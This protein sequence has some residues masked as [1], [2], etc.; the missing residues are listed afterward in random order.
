MKAIIAAGG[1]GTR[2]YPLTFT[3]NK[4]LIPIA[5]RPLLSYPI[6]NVV[7]VGIKDVGVIVNPD[8]RKAV[9]D[10]VGDGSRWGIKVTYVEQ[11]AP[12]GLAHVVKVSEKFL[13]GSSF[14]YHLGDNIFSKGIKKPFEVFAKKKPD[15]LLTVVEHDENF[16]LGVPFFD[17]KGNLK[18]VVEKPK[19]PPN[20]YG[21][22]GLYMFSSKV[23]EAFKGK[24]QV[25]PSARGELE[26]VD[27]YNY[28]L[29]HGKKVEVAEVDGEWRDPGKFD[30]SL[31]ANKLMLEEKTKTKI[32]GKVDKDTSLSGEIEIGKGSRVVNSRIVGPVSIGENVHVRN[33]FIGPFTSIANECEIVNSSIEYSILMDDIHL[34]DVKGK[35][36]ASMIGKHTEIRTPKT[37]TRAPVYSFS[38][39][40][41]CTI[42]LPF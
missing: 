25:K 16:R 13:D 15:A 6:E 29:T 2:L 34:V 11:S 35:I 14:V 18:E 36:E 20:Q 37:K 22:P 19:S 28:M 1:K 27:L 33:S 12:L 23:F 42:E 9:E 38:V 8:T 30:D 7:E 31:E 5:N 10:Y 41:H 40:D 39:A 24:D 32:D 26:I 4:H 17:K 3:S 21:V